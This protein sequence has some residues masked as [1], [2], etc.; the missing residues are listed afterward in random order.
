[1]ARAQRMESP[2]EF[3]LVI[4]V[5]LGGTSIDA[6]LVDVSARVCHVVHLPTPREPER[7]VPAVLA[8]IG[9]LLARPEA[10]AMPVKG[11][12]IASAGLVD[13]AGMVIS[14]A[15]LRWRRIPLRERVLA[16][17]GLATVLENDT[18]AAAVAEQLY[19]AG[20]GA[21][22]LIYIGLGTGVGAGF[23]LG[24]ALYRGNG[25]AGEIGHMQMLRDGPVCACGRRGCLEALV[26]GRA[27]GERAERLAQQYPDS[28]LA[29][30]YRQM[31]RLSARDVVSV[32][33]Q[34]AVAAGLIEEVAIYVGVAVGNLVQVFDPDLI[35]LGGGV[36]GSGRVFL[37][38]VEQEAR[39]IASATSGRPL[40]LA[41]SSLGADAGVVG[42]A[43]LIIQHLSV[44]SGS[45]AT[46]NASG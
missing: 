28:G 20:A 22:H 3:G 33:G 21:Q 39:L 2:E 15:N 7:V 1:M 46:K 34:D 40:R 23:I 10:L 25:S 38:R 18:N 5:D 45:P 44:V 13:E 6:A 14:A 36:A 31:G 41:L 35:I 29:G 32:A 30:L 12:G 37:D 17:F 4:G 43:A 19:G 16:T 11:I 27:I 9:D 42:A 26:G 8:V 24:G